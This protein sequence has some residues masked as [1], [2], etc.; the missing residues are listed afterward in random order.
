MVFSEPAFVFLFL[1]VFLALYFLIPPSFRN[2][3]LLGGSLLFYTWGEGVYCLVMIAS[4]LFNYFIGFFL[5]FVNDLGKRKFALFCGIAGNLCLLCFFKYTAFIAS[6]L[7]ILFTKL[8]IPP[9]PITPHHLPLGISFFTFVAIS[10]IIDVYRK[11]VEAQRNLA[12]LAVYV[13]MFPHLIAGPIVRYLDIGPQLENRRITPTMFAMGI[14]RF[15]IGLAKKVIIANAVGEIADRIFV[16]PTEYVNFEVAW[17]G[18]I[19]FSFQLYFDFSGYSDMA[20]GLAKMLGFHF[21]ENFRY[22]LVSRSISEFW[23]RWHITLMT[24]LRDYVF[25]PMGGYRHSRLRGAF[26]VI[27]VFFLCG[28]WHGASWN[29]V[30]FGLFQGVLVIMERAQWCRS[31]QKVGVF[32][33]LYTLGLIWT[34]L[35]F[36]RSGSLDQ[37]LIFIRACVGLTSMG[38]QAYSAR[39]LLSN[40]DSLMLIVA[41]ICSVPLTSWLKSNVILK[42]WEAPDGN[43]HVVAVGLEIVSSVALVMTFLLSAVFVIAGTHN[44]F[45]YFHF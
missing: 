22:P 16:L 32:C 12:S 31:L 36:F 7:D 3:I 18:L 17:L 44:P 34:S 13:C 15:V 42:L 41:L 39:L 27:I 10:Y 35:A 40:Y 21:P 25:V 23:Q 1:P 29:F 9:L 5:G 30:I 19:S 28:L 37:A 4:I 2:I 8:N 38:F 11:R 14:R 45:I 26:N 33:H 6:N 24:W 43:S 20:I